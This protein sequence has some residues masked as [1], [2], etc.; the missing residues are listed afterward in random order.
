M[1][2]QAKAILKNGAL[3][4]A[5]I[6]AVS[7]TILYINPNFPREILAL[8]VGLLVAILAAVG[9]NGITSVEVKTAE[10][11][12]DRVGGETVRSITAN[13][14]IVAEPG[15]IAFETFSRS[16]GRMDW[17]GNP[18]PPWHELSAV[19]KAGWAA[20]AAAARKE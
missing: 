1:S 6:A 20:S 9:V 4:S 7:G 13:R 19:T 14:T 12:A 18:I 2:D 3:W 10:I 11:K 5:L 16:V 17:R 15:E 8:Y